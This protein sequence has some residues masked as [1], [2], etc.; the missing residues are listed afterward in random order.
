LSQNGGQA[1]ALRR[2]TRAIIAPTTLKRVHEGNVSNRCKQ[3]LRGSEEEQIQS[4]KALAN[5]FSKTEVKSMLN[6]PTLK[7]VGIDVTNKYLQK[8]GAG[9][10]AREILATCDRSGITQ[11]GYTS[12]YKQFK[13]S[14][15]AAGKGL[16]VHC[17]P[18]PYHVSIL[19]KEMNSKLSDF[20]GQY[21]SINN[22]L[23]ISSQA[24]S[25]NKQPDH[26]QLTAK[27]SLFVDIEQMQRTMVQLYRITPEGM[28]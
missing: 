21:Y 14:V 24:K 4:G 9:M 28:P 25:K 13:D 19:R 23:D 2:L 6:S 18:K 8:I 15:Q 11:E 17:L 22:F 1:K 16:K 20:V 27:N 26:V 7:S 10:G 12:V 3:R 5:I